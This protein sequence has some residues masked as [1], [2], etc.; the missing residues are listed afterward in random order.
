MFS[1]VIP[2]LGLNPDM[3]LG[4][5]KVATSKSGGLIVLFLISQSPRDTEAQ[6]FRNV[7]T[8]KASTIL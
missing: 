8:E 3:L 4:G 7:M 1:L 6:L 5:K 2:V